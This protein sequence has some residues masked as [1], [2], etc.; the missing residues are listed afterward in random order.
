MIS[1]HKGGEFDCT[2]AKLRGVSPSSY[3]LC[4]CIKM[5]YKRASLDSNIKVAPL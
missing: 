1:K 5:N 2:K 4:V 3:I